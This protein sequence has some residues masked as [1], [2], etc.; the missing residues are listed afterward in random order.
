MKWAEMFMGV[1][2]NPKVDDCMHAH[3]TRITLSVED[4]NYEELHGA[5]S[6]FNSDVNFGGATYE[7]T[8]HFML[9]VE[10]LDVVNF[11]VYIITYGVQPLGLSS[12]RVT[13]CNTSPRGFR[14][15]LAGMQFMVQLLGGARCKLQD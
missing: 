1:Q 11:T 4:A 13:G 9:R 10:I 6:G 15:H 2:L 8:V 5:Y 14:F 3:L 12:L 7:C